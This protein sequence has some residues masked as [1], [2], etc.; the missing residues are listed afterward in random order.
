MVARDFA[1]ERTLIIAKV[2]ISHWI[3]AVAVSLIHCLTSFQNQNKNKNKNSTSY[4][5]RLPGLQ[6]KPARDGGSPPHRDFVSPI[7]EAT[8]FPVMRNTVTRSYDIH[9]AGAHEFVLCA[10]AC[11][12]VYVYPTSGY[13]TVP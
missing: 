9:T 3:V 1:A 11:A 5:C 12:Q 13:S 7:Q 10:C 6:S 8:L 4:A 2:K